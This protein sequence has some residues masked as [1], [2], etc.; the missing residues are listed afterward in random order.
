MKPSSL[1]LWLAATLLSQPL[2]AAELQ[3]VDE[4]PL[5]TTPKLW[6]EQRLGV[7][8]APTTSGPACSAITTASASWSTACR[9]LPSRPPSAS[10]KQASPGASITTA[11]R[12]RAANPAATQPAIWILLAQLRDGGSDIDT[13]W[14]G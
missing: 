10:I 1:A 5:T 7:S 3:F 4:Q 6:L 11:G 12:C 8:L 14:S 2:L 9:W 13:L